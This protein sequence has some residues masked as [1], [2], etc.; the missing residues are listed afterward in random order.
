MEPRNTE[1]SRKSWPW[2]I[3]GVALLMVVAFFMLN[4]GDKKSTV[5]VL[6]LDSTA[7]TNVTNPAPPCIPSTDGVIGINV[8]GDSLVRMYQ[9]ISRLQAAL[10]ACEEGKKPTSSTS[11]SNSTKKKTATTP[12]NADKTSTSKTQSPPPPQNLSSNAM[13]ANLAIQKYRGTKDE[14][15]DVFLSFDQNSYLTFW[16]R[17]SRIDNISG[18]SSPNPNV[19]NEYRDVHVE[20]G[21]YV[22]TSNIIVDINMLLN[23]VSFNF[24]WYAGMHENGYQIWLPHEL[25]KNMIN[26]YYPQDYDNPNLVKALVPYKVRPNKATTLENRGYEYYGFTINY[27][28]L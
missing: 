1:T 9:E 18:L 3:A 13:G 24:A 25:Y 19:N 16:M 8:S 2:I 12:N 23:K 21:Y 20:D 5:A 27:E 17:K 22:V 6:P 26:P 7:V 14:N 28:P 10:K 4:R 11:S 15:S